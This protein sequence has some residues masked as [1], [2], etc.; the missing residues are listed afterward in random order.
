MWTA[1]VL[2]VCVDLPRVIYPPNRS[3][4][5]HQ[6]VSGLLFRDQPILQ[7]LAL[8]NALITVTAGT[9]LNHIQRNVV[10]EWLSR[11]VNSAHRVYQAAA[12]YLTEAETDTSATWSESHVGRQRPRIGI[13]PGFRIGWDQIRRGFQ[14]AVEAGKKPSRIRRKKRKK[15]HSYGTRPAGG[16]VDERKSLI[17]NDESAAYETQELMTFSDVNSDVM[18]SRE[19]LTSTTCFFQPAEVD[20]L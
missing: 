7:S 19:K 15:K 16:D 17:G 5:F 9:G 4:V 20:P 18:F 2:L 11:P 8:E 3:F 6:K 13:P 1:D 14:S 10:R 12:E